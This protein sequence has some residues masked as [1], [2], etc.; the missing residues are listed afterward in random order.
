M[1]ATSAARR[2]E[3]DPQ[4]AWELWTNLDRWPTFVEGFAH[5]REKRGDWP[6]E[7]SRVTWNSIPGGRGIVT[8]KVTGSQPGASFAT[9]VFEEALTGTQLATFGVADDGRTRVELRLD[10]TLTNH[11]PLKAAMD[12]L[13]IRRAL[14]QMLQRTLERFATEAAEEAAL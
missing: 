10:Y 5:I 9:Q 12:V 8:E 11:N 13:F 6:D 3:L 14:G 2:V 4:Q 1:A 7:G